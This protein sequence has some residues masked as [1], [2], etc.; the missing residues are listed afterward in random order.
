MHPLHQKRNL[1]ASVSADRPPHPYT[2]T[3]MSIVKSSAASDYQTVL[4]VEGMHCAACVRRVER[5]LVSV[6]GVASAS[7]DF[8]SGRAIIEL[9]G[10]APNQTA[11]AAAIERAGYRLGT[12]QS[13][14]AEPQD[15]A[16]AALIWRAATALA[17]GWA[18][19]V[20]M[21]INRWAELG[22]DRDLL[23]TLMFAVATPALAVA[24]WPIARQGLRLR[25]GANM[26]TLITLG[27]AAAWTY[28]VAATFSGGAFE[29]AGAAREV[30]FDTA[31]IIVGFVTLGRWLE[32]RVK[33]R[34]ASAVAGL[35]AL[36]P[37]RARVIRDGEELDLEADEVLVGDLLIARPGERIAVDGVVL[38]GISSVDEASLTGES[39]PVAKEAGTSVFAGTVNL[40]GAL[41][42][43]ARQVGAGTA[44]ARMAAAV[45]RAQ[46]SKAPIQ[47]LADRIAAVFVPAV[48]AV[49]A[50][51]FALWAAFGPEPAWTLGLLTAVAVL[52]VACPCALGLA[53]PATI[54]AGAGRA[55]ALG[56]LFRDAEALERA[57]R[58]NTV[59][60]DKTG[61]LTTGRHRVVAAQSHAL[62]E[63]DLIALTAAVES[64]SEH[65]LAA[66][67][68]ERARELELEIAPV[69]NFR[70]LPGRGAVGRVGGREVAVGN[71]RMLQELG[72]KTA[73][74]PS[75]R[76][77]ATAL[78]VALDGEPVGAIWTADQLKAGAREAVA[79]LQRI[80]V[81]VLMVTGDAEQVAQS[82][83][84][85]AGVDEV[86]ASA[87]P[88]EK[89]GII[90][91]LQA[92]GAVVAMV[93]DGV[94]DAPALAQADAGLA[95][96][97]GADL[98]VDAG[99]VTLM[100]DDPITAVQ[101]LALARATRRTIAQNLGFAFAYNL[102]LIPLAAGIG[103][104]IFDAVGGVPGGLEWA[105]GESGAFEP[106]IA[107]IAMMLS[108]L[109]VLTNA[110]RLQRW[111]PH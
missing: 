107:A 54:A 7:A 53:T 38:G 64:A 101:A 40:D 88:E 62:T 68:V 27:A 37:E 59:V 45:E 15:R 70:A 105:F 33:R 22:W 93:G 98:A 89:A 56:V 8:L 104:P 82:V 31:L 23:F 52:V 51:A 86:V 4:A 84:A 5:A 49:A 48:I 36:R 103:V 41:R 65:P 109:S 73:A 94:N 9:D 50:L 110:L 60:F 79:S 13:E 6:D 92:Q 55:A 69:D 19:F 18:M 81:R 12:P 14:A 80:G 96:R 3:A 10:E 39:A 67:V 87:L 72:I 24:G 91:G 34:A 71:L 78:F 42:Y 83:G 47:R 32:A 43:E 77:D 57:A 58:V 1:E 74:L 35:L 28:S 61:T 25:A 90:A 44:L 29:T 66:A 106:I 95:L 17:L 100:R 21:Q 111:R 75:A 76:P 108:S 63:R 85:Q 99:D 2:E 30:F 26:D 97:S 46:A 11:L 16:L 20:A 102:L